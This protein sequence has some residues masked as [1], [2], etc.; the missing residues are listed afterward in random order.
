[1]I[2]F[3]RKKEEFDSDEAAR[4]VPYRDIKVKVV[5]SELV[6]SICNVN[7]LQ[8]Y[9]FNDNRLYKGISLNQIYI[10]VWSHRCLHVYVAPI[11][12][13][14]GGRPS[15]HQSIAESCMNYFEQPVSPL[16]LT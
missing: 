1:M 13:A 2:Q 11:G 8:A 15:F 7:Y 12:L 3:K 4:R 5:R 16:K 9:A 6:G 14:A 10:S